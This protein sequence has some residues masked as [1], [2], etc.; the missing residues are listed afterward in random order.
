MGREEDGLLYLHRQSTEQLHHLHL[1]GEV[2]EGSGFVEVDDRRFLGQRFG[3]HHL[4][5]F[6]IAQGVHHPIS[7]PFDAHHTDGLVNDTEVLSRIASPETS[8]GGTTQAD[9]L[10]DGHIPYVGLLRQYHTNQSTQFLVCIAPNLFPLN[11]YLTTYLWLEGREGAQ[12]GGLA[13][14]VAAQQTGELAT[15]D[16]GIHGSSHHLDI[17]LA[18]IADTQLTQFYGLLTHGL[19]VLFEL[20]HELV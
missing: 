1:T 19:Y 6:S 12:K 17:L 2:E 9:E 5:P 4:L 13:D 16:G 7:K 11:E 14:A 10:A 3:N 18:L 8:V 15:I 20:L